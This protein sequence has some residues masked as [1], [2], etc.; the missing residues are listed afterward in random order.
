MCVQLQIVIW[1]R[2]QEMYGREMEKNVPFFP[3]VKIIYIENCRGTLMY[4]HNEEETSS[5]LLYI[6]STW[7]QLL[8]KQ[9][10]E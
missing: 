2:W 4:F 5:R 7:D 6:G 8:Y 3:D 10:G 9:L 1:I